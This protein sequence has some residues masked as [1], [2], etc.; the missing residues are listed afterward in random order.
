MHTSC[1]WRIPPHAHLRWR[2]WPGESE[3][4][5]HHGA[6]GDTHRLSWPAGL[7]L[8]YLHTV[9][10][11]DADTLGDWLAKHDAALPRETVL[12]ML[13][14]LRRLEL[15]SCDACNEDADA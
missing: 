4:V 7:V 11:C 8:E 13:N 12:A 5:F 3:Y 1:L 10:A 14:D 6:S 9:N 2:R 15:L